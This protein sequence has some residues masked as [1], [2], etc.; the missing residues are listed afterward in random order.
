MVCVCVCVCVTLK[1]FLR[2]EACVCSVKWRGEEIPC[3]LGLSI[4]DTLH[5]IRSEQ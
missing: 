4:L 2:F 5:L 1:A 3:G